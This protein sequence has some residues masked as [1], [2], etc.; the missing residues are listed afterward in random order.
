MML[1]L[2]RPRL[3][4]FLR[5]SWNNYG[6]LVP[7]L[8]ACRFSYALHSPSSLETKLVSD[9]VFPVEKRMMILHRILS[10]FS[11]VNGTNSLCRCARRVDVQT[12]VAL[13][14]PTPKMT[15]IQQVVVC[16]G[17][18]LA[19]DVA[20]QIVVQK[21]ADTNVTTILRNCSESPKQLLEYGLETCVCFVMQT[22]ENA[23][24]TEDVS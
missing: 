17:G 16:Y 15:K 9:R 21:P 6:A 4:V 1:L 13:W 11:F 7:E 24:P 22:V 14:H 19:K 10:I 8:A 23:S 3:P 12:D 20:E 5:R 18:E 2:C